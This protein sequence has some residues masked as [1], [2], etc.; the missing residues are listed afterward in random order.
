MTIT[1]SD[2]ASTLIDALKKANYKYFG[3]IEDMDSLY[4]EMKGLSPKEMAERYA[5]RF[6]LREVNIFHNLI[7]DIFSKKRITLR[8]DADTFKFNYSAAKAAL[9]GSGYVRITGQRRNTK[10]IWV[11]EDKPTFTHAREITNLYNVI[12]NYKTTDEERDSLREVVENGEDIK[13]YLNKQNYSIAQYTRLLVWGTNLK[14]KL[15]REGKAAKHKV[16]EAVQRQTI[17]RFN[18]QRAAANGETVKEPE[19]ET[20][21]QDEEEPISNM[22]AEQLLIEEIKM[23]RMEIDYLKG[24]NKQQRKYIEQLKAFLNQ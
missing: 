16:T 20:Q 13:E 17:K 5:E 11:K 10:Y 12:M 7:S 9:E 19:E 21:Y 23:M 8:N 4:E 14:S 15:K 24:I 18:D 22:P 6:N 3:K 2:F 1:K